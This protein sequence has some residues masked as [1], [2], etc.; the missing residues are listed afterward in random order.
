[1]LLE[2]GA[3]SNQNLSGTF[4]N[5]TVGAFISRATSDVDPHSQFGNVLETSGLRFS[6]YVLTGFV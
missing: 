5:M 3:T 1:M 2:Q 6:K 4:S